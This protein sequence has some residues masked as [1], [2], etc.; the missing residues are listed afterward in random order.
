MGYSSLL[1]LPTEKDYKQKFIEEYCTNGPITTWDGLTVVFYPEMFEHA[2]YKRTQKQWRASKAVVDYD[3]C[4]R[5]LWIKEALQDSTIIPRVGYDK[6]TG[7]ND[8]TRRV[9]LVTRNWYVVVIRSD[10]NKWRFV[11]AYIIDNQ[12]TYNLLLAAPKWYP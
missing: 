5:M 11:T 12:R 9:T 2:F 6:A 8:N 7:K 4:K 10:G 3:R 1:C